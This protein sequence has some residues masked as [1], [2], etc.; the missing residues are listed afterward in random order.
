MKDIDY[1][2]SSSS[3]SYYAAD[4]ADAF[5]TEV[6]YLFIEAFPIEPDFD[7]TFPEALPEAFPEAFAYF[8]ACWFN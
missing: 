4:G 1:L 2:I 7:P 5:K 8:Y 6:P 3:S